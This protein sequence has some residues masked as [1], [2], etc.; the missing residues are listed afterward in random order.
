M[1]SDKHATR[2]G[3]LRHCSELSRVRMRRRV[4]AALLALL[5]AGIVA[6]CGSS[7]GSG[8]A[9]DSS[10]VLRVGL[11]SEPIPPNPATATLSGTSASVMFS[12]AYAPLF[13]LTPDN[14]VEPALV[15]K[16]H[17]IKGTSEPNT[18]FEFT[19]RKDAKFSD[20]T[21][22]TGAAVVHWLEYFTNG[23]GPL[24]GILGESPEFTAPD[25]WTV[26]IALTE[27]N[28]TLPEVLS[29]AGQNI[30]FVL[31]PKA[32][33]NPKML[34]RETDGAGPY[35]MDPAKSVRA[36]HYTYV[37]NPHFYE[38]SARKF[39]EVQV[40][41]ITEA[42]SR[43]QSQLSGQLDVGEGDD[44]TASAAESAGLEVASGPH[45]VQYLTLDIVHGA[46]PALKDPRVRE[47]LNLAIDRKSIATAL[48]GSSGSPTSSFLAA[49]VDSGLESYWPYDPAKAKKLLKEAGYS[50]GLTLK[51]IAPG[52][53]G[54][55]SGE[56]L[57]RAVAKD[58]EEVGVKLEITTYAAE[59]EYSE[60]VFSFKAPLSMLEEGIWATTTIW[61]TYLKP[62]SIGNMFGNEPQMVK[63]YEEGVKSADPRNGWK[64]MYERFTSKAFVVPL[65]AT[66]TLY[67]VSNATGGVQL[68]HLRG[69][70]LATE[71]YAK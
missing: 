19:L 38:P 26:R 45:A 59:A 69:L 33:A 64:R 57:L 51:A 70:A 21:P 39:Q 14:K 66:E 16:W 25:R 31:G 46:A 56:P 55:N 30:G 63:Y 43:L 8:N 29:D 42:S 36:N 4:A 60:A 67:Y 9:S 34:S 11:A 54:G 40:K 1:G 23:P 48:F 58:L 35:M 62:G 49:D 52:A 2:S 5:T 7:G 37:P 17:Y 24:S 41:I 6:G 71:W 27:P 47:A 10:S 15:T 68:G 28:P 44:S 18:E 61:G 20:G 13:H 22:V 53:F 12:L 65:V 50:D 32:I 3:V